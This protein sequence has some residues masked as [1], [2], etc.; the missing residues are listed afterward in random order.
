MD[1]CRI[2]GGGDGGKGNGSAAGAGTGA[3]ETERLRVAFNESSAA[4]ET[5]REVAP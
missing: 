5:L 1:G 4:K 3:N 2:A